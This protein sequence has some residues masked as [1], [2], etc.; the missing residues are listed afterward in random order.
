MTVIVNKYIDNKHLL[1]KTMADVEIYSG[2]QSN[3]RRGHRP[4]WILS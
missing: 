1:D 4:S 2:E 3:I